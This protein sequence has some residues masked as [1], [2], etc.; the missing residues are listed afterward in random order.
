MNQNTLQFGQ[1]TRIKHCQWETSHDCPVMVKF[2]WSQDRMAYVRSRP[3][4]T[5]QVIMSMWHNHE[6][7]VK[8]KHYLINDPLLLKE[9]DLF[10]KCRLSV[11]NIYQIVK[12]KYAIKVRY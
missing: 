11:A 3:T 9:L 4:K 7:I 10:V 5:Q 6:L 2:R 1:G 8:D 12:K